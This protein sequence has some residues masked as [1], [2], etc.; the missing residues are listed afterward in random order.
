MARPRFHFCLRTI[1]EIVPSCGPGRPSA[2]FK[3]LVAVFW[4][5]LGV[6]NPFHPFSSK[7]SQLK[8]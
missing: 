4:S 2:G 7:F 8:P 1:Q 3:I 5:T 6:E